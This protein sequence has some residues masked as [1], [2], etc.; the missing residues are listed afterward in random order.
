VFDG[1]NWTNPWPTPFSNV[2]I[3][4]SVYSVPKAW[5]G[6]TGADAHWTLYRLTGETRPLTLVTPTLYD[7][8]CVSNI[9]LRT[10]YKADEPAPPRSVHHHPK[11]GLAIGG[12]AAVEPIEA[13]DAKA[14]NL[15]W[16]VTRIGGAADPPVDQQVSRLRNAGADRWARAYDNWRTVPWT[17]EVLC[18]S[19][20]FDVFS[21]IHYFE[22]FRRLPPPGS[23]P[24]ADACG[25]VVFVQ[26]FRVGDGSLKVSV[27]LSDC[28]E[29]E[30]EFMLPLG[31]I[32]VGPKLYW[33]V[34]MSGLGRERYAIIE[35]GQSSFREVL[36]VAGGGC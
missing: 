26:G 35:I 23:S 30:L 25:G 12:A 1:R 14:L 33:A 2:D 3:P 21:K 7:T 18:E 27:R 8:H 22:A 13:L 10:D 28:D 9:G 19:R 16:L 17:L 24:P 20:G 4:I 31:A 36:G 6:K 5:W 11:D 34:Q 15:S 32:R 29:A